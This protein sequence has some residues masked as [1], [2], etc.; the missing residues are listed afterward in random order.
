MGCTIRKNLP[1]IDPH[2]SCYFRRKIL[3]WHSNNKRHF[4][5]RKTKN[6]YHILVAEI[7]L[8]QTDAAKA[9][10]EYS[11]FIKTFPT[12]RKL[13]A[14]SKSS[15]NEFICRLGLDYRISRLINI[16]DKLEK[17]F[18]GTVPNTKEELLKLPGVGEYI[19]NA[20]LAAAYHKR[21]AVLDTNVIRILERFFGL[22]SS[23][24]R[25]RTDPLLWTAAQHLLPQKTNMCKIW[26]YAMLDFGALVCSHYR[27]Q[28]KKCPCRRRCSYLSDL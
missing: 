6:P 9:A 16:A 15:V 11:S 17:R 4:P 26:N 2:K 25:A 19:A 7:L 12:P 21:V 10:K 22:R 3:D 1:V 8:Q 13:A 14:A 24:A 28:C 23:R 20:V 27:P 18:G 5:W